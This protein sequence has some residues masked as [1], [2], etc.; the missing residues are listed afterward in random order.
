[1]GL[2]RLSRRNGAVGAKLKLGQPSIA[3]ERTQKPG[4]HS[5]LRDEM[6]RLRNGFYAATADHVLDT[7]RMAILA[8]YCSPPLLTIMGPGSTGAKD[9][10]SRAPSITRGS[11]KPAFSHQ[12]ID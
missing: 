9:C 5:Y 10:S 3:G 1:M 12:E 2:T 7:S 11:S 6:T 8:E 4:W